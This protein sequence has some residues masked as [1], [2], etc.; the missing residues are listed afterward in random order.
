M[1]LFQV[2]KGGPSSS[3]TPLK[4]KRS[5]PCWNIAGN[6]ILFEVEINDLGADIWSNVNSR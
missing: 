6:F 1:I 2:D 3:Q 4:E 5:L